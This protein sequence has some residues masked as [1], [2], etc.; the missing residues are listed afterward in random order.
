[1]RNKY[2]K[3]DNAYRILVFSLLSAARPVGMPVTECS[4]PSACFGGRPG[5]RSKR[6]PNILMLE[7]S[8]RNPAI[9]ESPAP[10]VSIISALTTG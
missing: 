8:V 10:N 2:K 4:E 9:K 3:R 5:G 7:K 6:S 1:M